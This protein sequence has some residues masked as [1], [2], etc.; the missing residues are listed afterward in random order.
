MN[1]HQYRIGGTLATLLILLAASCS[2]Q[3]NSV[4]SITI[5]TITEQNFTCKGGFGS[6]T[7]VVT[8]DPVVEAV[9]SAP[10][11]LRVS[12]SEPDKVLFNVFANEGDIE[13]KAS[14]T[15]SAEGVAPVSFDITQQ[16]FNG[17]MVNTETVELTD[18]KPDGSVLVRCTSDYEVAFTQNPDGAFELTKTESG[19]SFS[20]VKPQ[21]RTAYIG[22][23]VIM[24]SDTD[25]E[26]VYIDITLPKKSDYSYLLGTWTVSRNTDLSNDKSDFTFKELVPGQSFSVTIQRE[27]LKDLPFT[28][29]LTK[30][31]KVRIGVQ[32]FAADQAA[33]RYYTIHFNGPSVSNPNATFIYATEGRYAWDAE[34]L[35]NEET[36]TVTLSFSDAGITPNNI[37]KQLNIWWSKGRYF[38]FTTKITSFE[39]LVLTKQYK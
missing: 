21:S 34:P 28:A 26:P 20:A 36:G 7:L 10:E 16:A 4:S 6:A 8:G 27:E 11:W 3:D 33:D 14:I 1:K 35:F 31:G 32:G 22:R 12:M 2:K 23:A 24:P 18:I 19:I 13:R 9:S 38:A 37:P 17:I 15:V 25:I 5:S 39:D 29:E 30:E